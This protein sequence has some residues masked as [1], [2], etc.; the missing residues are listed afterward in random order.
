[1]IISLPTG[2][3]KNSIIIFS[4]DEDKKEL[5]L[6][7]RIILM[8]QLKN[9]IITKR[10]ELKKNIQCIGDG[11]NIYNKEKLITI[12]VYNSVHIVKDEIFD[13]IYID[14]AH[15]I[16]KP[17]IYKNEDDENI[18]DDD[19]EELK[20]EENYMNIIKGFKVQENN[21]YLSATID[22]I[23]NFEYY[24]KS[25]REM[26]DLNYLCDYTINIPI[27]SKNPDNSKICKYFK[28]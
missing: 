7:P 1:M 27:F 23:P 10:P 26:I 8:D 22:K 12:C 3:G 4:I 16:N 19:D 21:V 18:K 24:F 25:L 20:N 6:V 17:D 13:K 9:E 14:E 5:M 11:K 28:K 15:H 2:C